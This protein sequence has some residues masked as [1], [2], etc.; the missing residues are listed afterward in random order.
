MT[1]KE[2]VVEVPWKQFDIF[3]TIVRLK[4]HWP[5]CVF[6]GVLDKYP[7][8]IAYKD[9]E[10]KKYWHDDFPL[11]VTSTDRICFQFRDK[12]I[13]MTYEPNTDAAQV[14]KDITLEFMKINIMWNEPTGI[15]VKADE[16]GT[17]SETA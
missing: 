4:S 11:E 6:E 13:T 9:A 8:M 7:D 16:D 5:Q 12:S 15:F 17:K 1:E 2:V 10:A 3:P 14:V